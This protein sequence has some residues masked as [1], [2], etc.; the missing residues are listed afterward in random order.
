MITIQDLQHV[1]V[2]GS[3]FGA[4]ADTIANNPKLASDVQNALVEWDKTR[5]DTISARAVKAETD[6]LALQ[7]LTSSILAKAKE[8][9][10]PEVQMLVALAEQPAKDRAIDEAKQA[11]EK[12]Q[13]KLA[14]LSSP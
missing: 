5:T 6:L 4:V 12:A 9:D 14:A 1:L 13:A 11:V 10:H 8:S 7:A 3:N 2:D